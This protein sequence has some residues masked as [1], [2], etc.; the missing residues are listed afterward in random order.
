MIYLSTFAVVGPL[1]EA[2]APNIGV[3]A[4]GRLVAGVGAGGATVV[5][6]IY[7]SEISP[8]DKRGIF[9]AFTQILTNCGILITQALGLFL[10]RGQMWR[11]IL[12]VGGAIALAQMI[13]LVLGGQESPKYLA[14]AGKTSQAHAVL[15]KLGR[16]RGLVE[17]GELLPCHIAH[18]KDGIDSAD[19]D[20][21]QLLE[22]VRHA[23]FKSGKGRERGAW[24]SRDGCLIY[25]LRL[26]Y[27]VHVVVPS[28][29]NV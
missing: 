3:M 29:W 20:V 28:S 8:P 25:L 16:F 18:P 11:I 4:F 17:A 19:D 2:A 24:K 26:P 21:A 23:G 6:P 10:S 13:G 9:G 7:I 27:P 14:D 15:R 12:G 1:F 22:I 5:V